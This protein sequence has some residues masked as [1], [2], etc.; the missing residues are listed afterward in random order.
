M[1]MVIFEKKNQGEEGR[2]SREYLR[3]NAPGMEESCKDTQRK[4]TA[5]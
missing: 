1:R 3:R 5:C 4:S 2:E